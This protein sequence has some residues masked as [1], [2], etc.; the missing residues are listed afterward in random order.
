MSNEEDQARMQYESVVEMLAA[1]E[2]DYDRKEEL[3]ELALGEDG[4]ETSTENMDELEELRVAANGCVNRHHAEQR[5]YESP[6]SI[7][8]RSGWYD[9]G[10]GNGQVPEEFEIL[11]CTG[12]PAVRIIGGLNEG[13]PHSAWLEY[14]N[15][16]TPWTRCFS[17]EQE[18]LLRY[19]QQFH[20]WRMI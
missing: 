7:Q 5:I 15:W 14:Q 20:F 10:A 11:L 17:A 4:E 2:C 1:L 13:I 6:L 16:G 3:E 19:S 8:V 18:V 12:G 9:P